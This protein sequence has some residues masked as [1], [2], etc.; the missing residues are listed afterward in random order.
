MTRTL[1]LIPIALLGI[2]FSLSTSQSKRDAVAFCEA[3]NPENKAKRKPWTTSRITGS[4]RPAP[5]YQLKRVFGKL[6][7]KDPTVLTNAPGTDRLFLTEL[8]GKI[9]SFNKK[10]TK[11]DL[12]F[13]M[14][15]H[16]KQVYRVY[17]LTFHPQFE[18][19]R[20]C[21]ICYVDKADQPNG[22]RVSRFKVSKTDPPTIDPKSEE[23]I[24]S[25][26]SGGHN[27]GCLK[28]GSDG[29]LYV[30]AGDAGPAFPPDPRK[31]GQDISNVRSTVMRI[32]VD[33]P[34]K[35]KPY[36]IPSDNPFVKTAGARGE[37]WAY[38]FRNPWK[39][40]FD[41]KNGDLWIGD[42]GW[43]LWEM[44]YRVQKGGN[45]GWS[46]REGSQMVHQE[47]ERGPTPIL[48]PTTEHSHVESRSITGG[49][50]Y[51]GE[52]LKKLHGA[53]IYG[54]YVTGKL[55]ALRHDG[56]KVT[57]RT[58]IVDAPIQ[59]IAFAVDNDQELYVM[60]YD[61][62]I[63]IIEPNPDRGA[64]ENFPR[65]L[66][67]T[68]L[69][70]NV[71]KHETAQGVLP[72][73]INA[74]PWM[75]HATADRF[76][77]LPNL[78][79][80]GIHEKNDPQQGI[81]RGKWKYPKDAV[82]AKTISLEMETG[83]PK[84][85]RRL[86]TQIL[87]FDGRYWQAYNY[88][89]NEKQT[90]AI[91]DTSGKDETYVIQDKTAPG[92]KRKQTWHFAS[93]TECLLCHSSRGGFVSGFI[94]EQVLGNGSFR[95]LEA[96]GLFEKPL[97][98]EIHR[99][100]A[101]SDRQ[102]SLEDQARSYLHVNCAGCHQRGGGGTAAMELRWELPLKRLNAIDERPTQGTFAIHDAKVIASDDPYRSVLFYR[103]SKHGPGRMPYFG[104][105]ITHD[106]GLDLIEKWIAS[107]PRDPNV[108]I[109]P[110]D[111]LRRRQILSMT[112][113]RN[114]EFPED[115]KAKEIDNLLSSTSGA[116]M[117]SQALN[118]NSLPKKVREQILAKITL[119]TPA[120]VRDLFERF[121][122]EDRRIKRL[123]NFIKPDMILRLDGNHQR[124]REMFFSS[125]TVQCRNCHRIDKMGGEVGPDL[126]AIGKKYK[127]EAL[128]ETILEP[129]KNIDP[130]FVSYLIE[131]KR[132]VVHLGL[133]IS[134]NEKEIVLR[135]AQA[136]E[137]RVKTTDV[138]RMVPQ[139]KSLMPELLLREMTAQQ[140]A[141]LL[142][143]LRTLK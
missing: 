52:R 71:A 47:R 42:V 119:E 39:M 105:T 5:P 127:Q 21:F 86:E 67:E 36:S 113:I 58:E 135:D 84:S 64:N 62:S 72:Y 63:H 131:T 55:W 43:E 87:H 124:G 66:S 94:P 136:K 79:T 25:W 81:N 57:S 69:F 89:W 23:L 115:V 75:D 14:A 35:D 80:L 20:E 96:I 95:D 59:V 45:Y 116:L 133:L 118:R 65:K 73:E 122:P 98:K 56:T 24:L 37:V 8:R 120:H 93:Q 49:F 83:N 142:A 97:T 28:F 51:R 41:P 110:S 112:Q 126:S 50:V 102:A 106:K 60:G 123:G 1:W 104:S 99:M 101:M 132:G 4:L 31:S 46:I 88:V 130:K 13:D 140:A 19:N 11:P 18:K 44:I 76:I 111:R 48:P 3:P 16:L 92:G 74:E 70:A 108:I 78:G 34:G 30:T 2:L 134:R 121:L 117:L 6:E 17:G 143:Y 107:L 29:Y 40:S 27:G 54:D 77:A 128:L 137:I 82:L 85:R 22:T 9:H 139:Q 109:S 91:L 26:P 129:S 10:S 61:G 141:D 90:D 32:D 138:E 38:G 125:K 100:R 114:K 68:G 33:H 103:M 53:Y 15:K 12:F 7:F